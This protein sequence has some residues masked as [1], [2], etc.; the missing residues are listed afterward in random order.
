M[1]KHNRKYRQIAGRLIR[2]LPEFE[3]LK[4]CGVRVAYLECDEEKKKNR[5][6]VYADCTQ[7]SGTYDWCCSY[8]FFITVYEPSVVSFTEKQLETLIRH[9]LHHI[10]IDYGGIEP[11]FYIVP[12]DVEEFWDI[13]N[14]CGL[15]WDSPTE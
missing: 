2:T 14:D 1:R 13:I 6:T 5:K 12:H 11:S 8:D 10:G 15:L 7:V 9:E 4:A 3:D